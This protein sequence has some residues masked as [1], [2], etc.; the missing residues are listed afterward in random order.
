MYILLLLVI[1][2]GLSASETE[3]KKYIWEQCM[4]IGNRNTTL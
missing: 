2:G 1:S 3:F 4:Y